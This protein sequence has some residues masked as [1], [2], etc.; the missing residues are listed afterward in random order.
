MSLIDE[1][2]NTVLNKL[3][4]LNGGIWSLAVDELDDMKERVI[5]GEDPEEILYEIG[6]EPDF[7]FAL[8]H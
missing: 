2:K 4:E 8:L 3:L 7:V 6:L 5:Y 1:D